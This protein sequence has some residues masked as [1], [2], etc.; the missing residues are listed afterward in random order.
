VS[1]Y[2]QKLKIVKRSQQMRTLFEPVSCKKEKKTAYSLM[3]LA[4]TPEEEATFRFI[5]I[6]IYM[7]SLEDVRL[8]FKN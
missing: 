2:Y 3:L 5:S 7:K 1:S 4:I 6:A 8:H